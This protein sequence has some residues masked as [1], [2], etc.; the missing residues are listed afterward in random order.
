MAY[1]AGWEPGMDNSTARSKC[2]DVTVPM[3][4]PLGYNHGAE[5]LLDKMSERQVLDCMVKAMKSLDS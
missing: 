2:R 5:F 1:A 3:G 4:D